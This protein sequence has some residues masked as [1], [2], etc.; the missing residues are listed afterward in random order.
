MVKRTS[1]LLVGLILFFSWSVLARGQN[2]WSTK[3]FVEWS[4]AEAEQVLNDSPWAKVSEV[5]IRKEGQV[6]RVAGAPPSMERNET[7]STT[8][9]GAEV[10]IDFVFTLRLRSA[11]PVRQA[12][13][14]LKQ[15]AA[16]YNQMDPKQRASFDASTKGLLECPACDSNYVVSLTSKSRNSPGADAVYSVFKG[17]QLEDIKR[18]IYIAD[19]QRHRREL[20]HFVPPKAPGEEAIFFFPRLD[21][22][23]NPLFTVDSK[24]IVV[25]LTYNEVNMF[26]NFRIDITKLIDNGRVLF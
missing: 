22:K 7:N 13:V 23:G 4:K 11:L 15:M 19:E 8:S 16:K 25:N 3:P 9:T 5:R 10:P 6:R 12:L 18:Y 20:V 21:E 24:E 17:A 14:R 26:T 1:T 2:F